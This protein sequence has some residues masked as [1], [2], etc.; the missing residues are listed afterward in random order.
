VIE[1]G[2]EL[3]LLGTAAQRTR[4]A[5]VFTERRKRR[6]RPG[7]RRGRGSGH[8]GSSSAAHRDHR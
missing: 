3:V 1:R 2:A 4:F 8:A 6:R 7:F 5:E